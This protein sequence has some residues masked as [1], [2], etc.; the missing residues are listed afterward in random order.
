MPEAL[1]VR[2]GKSTGDAARVRCR[3]DTLPRRLGARADAEENAERDDKRSV[4]GRQISVL[5]KLGLV[6]VYLINSEPGC[7]C[8]AR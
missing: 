8:Q 6:S 3:Q 1:G 2:H 7:I 5:P 4:A